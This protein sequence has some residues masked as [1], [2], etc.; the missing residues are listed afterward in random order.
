MTALQRLEKWYSS[1]CNG[2]WEHQHGIDI[3]TLDNPGWR[4]TID[5]RGT[6]GEN[7]N[8]DRVKLERTANDW[9]QYWVE[10]RKFNAACGSENLSEA[11][12][13]F[14]EWFDGSA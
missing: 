5:L 1:Q 6:R 12:D 14:C 3:G 7:K 4:I 13:I 10:D 11:I 9:L 8:L 2:D